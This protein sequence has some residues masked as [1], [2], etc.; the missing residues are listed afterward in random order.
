MMT[1]EDKIIKDLIAGN[2][3]YSEKNKSTI[4]KYKKKQSPKV[5]ILT[6]S[7]SRVIPEYIFNKSIGELFI[8]R[9]AG[10]IAFENSVL[11]SIEYAVD[12]LKVN[13]VIILGHTNCGAV[14][15]SEE[16]KEND[17][18]LL[19]EIKKSFNLDKN[20]F[21]ANILRQIEMIPK[22]SEIIKEKIQNNNLKLIGA[23][24]KIETGNVEFMID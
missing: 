17:N 12:H 8:I 16:T 3:I 6:C 15:A 22:R 9:V 19:N 13:H 18:F 23:L 14:K 11:K 1:M 4:K 24:Y 20:H 2:K 10:N 5:A 7:D 21:K